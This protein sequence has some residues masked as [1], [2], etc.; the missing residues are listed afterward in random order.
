[1]Q[2]SKEAMRWLMSSF[3]L[4]LTLLQARPELSWFLSIAFGDKR[5]TPFKESQSVSTES[6]KAVAIQSLSLPTNVCQCL[7]YLR[8]LI[9][10]A[11]CDIVW[12]CISPKFLGWDLITYMTILQ[13]GDF[14]W[15]LDHGAKPKYPHKITSRKVLP[16]PPSSNTARRHHLWGTFLAWHQS[17]WYF[18]LCL[19]SLQNSEAPSLWYF[20]LQ[21]PKWTKA[22]CQI[23]YTNN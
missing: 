13:G 11:I 14:E 2:I 18:E 16:P 23:N 4:H 12:L 15:S 10:T 3:C 19:R 22:M 5:I 7:I 6:Y 20:F 21:H 1:M 9:L 17:C 8:N